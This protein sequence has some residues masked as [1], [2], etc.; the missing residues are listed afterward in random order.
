[1]DSV[2]SQLSLIYPADRHDK[3]EFQKIKL[4][5]VQKCRAPLAIATKLSLALS[6]KPN[7]S[8]DTTYTQD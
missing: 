6:L 5:P 8:K 1:M 7:V 2:N 4:K 3:Y